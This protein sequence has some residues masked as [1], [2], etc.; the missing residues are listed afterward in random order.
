MVQLTKSKATA[1]RKVQL[2]CPQG[3][4]FFLHVTLRCLELIPGYHSFLLSGIPFV[5]PPPAMWYPP[6]L[7]GPRYAGRRASKR[8]ND[9]QYQAGKKKR[10]NLRMS[11]ATRRNRNLF[12]CLFACVLIFK[13][14]FVEKRQRQKR[15]NT[16]IALTTFQR[17]FGL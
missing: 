11:S 16:H 17:Y 10:Q 3:S 6:K 5:A 1:T 4:C 9:R 2:Y 12:V 13:I 8:T 14:N 7:Y 15:S